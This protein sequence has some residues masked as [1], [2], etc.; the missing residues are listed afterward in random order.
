M[1]SFVSQFLGSPLLI[2]TVIIVI[3]VIAFIYHK[4]RK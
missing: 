2:L 3:D 1:E 4:I